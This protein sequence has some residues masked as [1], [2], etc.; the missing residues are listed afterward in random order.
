MTFINRPASVT[1]IL[2]TICSGPDIKISTQLEAYIAD[3]EAKQPDR[4]H[5]ITAILSVIG[6][7]YTV[8]LQSLLED[9][10]SDLEAKQ[11]PVSQLKNPAAFEA[12]NAPVWSHQQTVA[13]QL[14]R[15]ER[16]LRKANNYQ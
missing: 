8:G 16:A 14:H 1:T 6:S 2:K 11:Q 10:I 7:H 13:R 15:Q 9:Y 4:P 5:E 3:L 12:N